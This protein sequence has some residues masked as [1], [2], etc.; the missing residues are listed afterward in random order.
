M[1][2]QTTSKVY[3]P[4]KLIPG[5][6]QCTQRTQRTHDDTHTHTHGKYLAIVCKYM[7]LLLIRE[8]APT[9]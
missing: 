2:H 9:H 3:V 5:Y 8:K 7:N 4:P 6:T 1:N